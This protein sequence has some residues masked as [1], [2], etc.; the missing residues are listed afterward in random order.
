VS[1]EHAVRDLLPGYA[2]GCLDP[3]EKRAVAVHLTR[4][5][6]C[7]AELET[8]VRVTDQLSMTA[9]AAEPSA[10]LE[11]R[12]LRGVET[13]RRSRFV[14]WRP[15]LTAVAAVIVVALFTGNLL[16]WTGVVHRPGRGAAAT[17]LT[18]TLAGTG[19]ARDAFGTVVLDPGDREGVLAVTGLPRLDSEHRYQV[20]L[21]RGDERR[22]AGLFGVDERG[23]GSLLLA[24]PADFSDFRT[25]GITVEPAGGSPAP[26]G[27]R[28]MTG[29]L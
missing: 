14:T 28:V 12:I 26:T 5:P 6:A 4:C 29:A 10:G 19:D 23:Y 2:L 21:I 27:A 3:E 18:A 7:R 13:R 17:M 22:S 11:L 24:V 20:W 1:D 9:P 15:A 16:Q 25:L 8:Y